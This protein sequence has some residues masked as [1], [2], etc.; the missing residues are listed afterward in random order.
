MP[1]N[2]DRAPGAELPRILSGGQGLTFARLSANGL[3]QAAVTVA[4]ALVIQRIFD[5]WISTGSPWR[6]PE[7]GRL[8][9]AL[10]LLALL[11]AGAR[12]L[13]R[14]DAERVG[15]DYI[16][17]VRLALFD[18]LSALSPRV[19]HRRSRGGI[20]MRFINDLAALRQWVSLGLAR[21][22]VAGILTVGTL[23][24]LAFLN[25]PLALT[26]GGVIVFGSLVAFALGRPME[27]VVRDSRRRRAR[28][29]ANV[30]EKV[31][32]M[33]AVQVHGQTHRE[34]RRIERQGVQL[35]DSMIGRARIVGAL[36]GLAE[37][38]TAIATAAA[39]LVG[40]HQV[41][42]GLASPGTVVAALAIVG[43]LVPQVRALGRVWEYW[44]GAKVSRQKIE[45][46]LAVPTLVSEQEGA[47]SLPSGSGR[48]VVDDVSV[49]GCLSGVSAAAEAGQRVAVVGPNG[50]GK[51]SLLGLAARLLDPDQGRVSLDGQDLHDTKMSSLRS[52]VG[53]ISPDAPLLRGTLR[54]NLCYRAPRASRKDLRRVMRLCRVDEIC[55]ELPD[56]L[57]TLLTEGAANLSVGQRQRVAL[58]RTLL[59]KPRILLL[60][61]ADVNLDPAARKALDKALRRFEGTI[62][63]V[64]HDVDRVRKVDTVWH[65]E[66][67]RLVECGPPQELLGGQGPTAKLFERVEA[68]RR[69]R[70]SREARRSTKNETQGEGTTPPAQASIDAG[71]QPTAGP[72]DDGG[73]KDEDRT[74]H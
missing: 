24:V 21:L 20:L 10:V 2:R 73:E 58:A 50:A 66:G 57:E 68:A 19:I 69:K 47:R 13:E 8:G 7:L 25:V 70:R 11:A 30:T 55:E 28:L 54:R 23:S 64:T 6:D 42:S 1:E 22:L 43:I 53:L 18:H 56:G 33:A 51:S 5:G 26:V 36:R 48:L 71:A 14:L 63:M 15:Q 29:A 46:F 61:E 3:V 49:A 12:L 40:A 39:L 38:T 31:S 4:S 32:A 41:A 72:D 60:D 67:G 52:A 44:H 65:L 27:R 35:R 17:R 16:F 74:V 37:G 62:V 59:G 34:R 45:E 9:A